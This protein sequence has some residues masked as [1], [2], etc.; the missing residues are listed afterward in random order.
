MPQRTLQEKLSAEANA[1]MLVLNRCIHKYEFYGNK[2]REEA[3]KKRK[4]LQTKG[5]KSI[6]H[7]K[8]FG[9]SS[10]VVAKSKKESKE[11]RKERLRL[12]KMKEDALRLRRVR[13]LQFYKGSSS[14]GEI[15]EVNHD[16]EPSF[17]PL[18]APIV[19]G[20]QYVP[21]LEE[22]A[23]TKPVSFQEAIDESVVQNL[24]RT[25][26]VPKVRESPAKTCGLSSELEES[27]NEKFFED[28]ND[29]QWNKFKQNLDLQNWLEDLVICRESTSDEREN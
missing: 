20:G 17:V 10:A 23:K 2:E 29:A 12:L 26:P 13:R 4:L 25:S 15:E 24:S 7:N 19:N 9:T 1:S 14:N 16:S 22:K 5:K 28:L 3:E 18:Q 11:E 27:D 8:G 21:L 6:Q